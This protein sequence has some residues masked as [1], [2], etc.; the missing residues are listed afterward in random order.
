[1]PHASYTRLEE[2]FRRISALTDA[3]AILQWDLAT[4]MPKGG[5]RGRADQLAVLK[6]LRHS[7]LC[8][9]EVAQLLDA[10]GADVSLDDWQRANLKEMRRAHVLAS[11]VG[12]PE[13]EALSRASSACEA[14]WRDARAESDFSIVRPSLEAL[15]PLVRATAEARAKA[16]GLDPYDAL[17]EEYEPGGRAAEIDP[18]F[19]RLGEALPSLLTAVLERQAEA[20][21]P[22][23][24]RGPFP[25]EAQRRLAV[26]FMERLGFDF[27]H[28]RLD[29][30]LHPF[31]GGTP[32]DVRITTRYDEHD[33]RPALMG[34]LHETGHALYERG[35]PKEW[36][37]LPV[38]DA[39]GMVLHESQ[40]LLIEMQ[41]CRSRAFLAF[42]A[43]LIRATFNG[44]GPAWEAEA[45]YRHYAHVEPGLI[46][47]N[48][49]EVTY[50]AHVI[51][52]YRLEKAL[53]AGTLKVADLPGAW[54]E[55]MRDL[56]GITPP[57]D[58][59]G[60][61][62]DIHWYDGAFGYFPT[63]TL[64]AIAAAQL[65]DA[66]CRA[67]PGLSEG[68]AA[69][70]F[71]P[72]INWLRTHVHSQGSSKSAREILIAATGR[73]LDAEAFVTHLER[74]YLG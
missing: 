22:P 29:V 16:L 42:A 72:L 23:E 61:L 6:A 46:R 60:C 59:S 53:L 12:Q 25:I 36:R 44:S 24:F 65:F 69:G 7:L 17:L 41:V 35:L 63:Y 50:P 51:L 30:S 20:G 38:A 19:A 27:H 74:R 32:D 45:L 70:E 48:A 31:C 52:R 68:I 73:P 4:M 43:P 8:S 3:G 66:A 37:G 10:A 26:Q 56:L 57:D 62:Q 55:G 28:G 15:V 21:P 2:W 11:A 58:R 49:D 39:R 71:A 13:V 40:S 67:E 33:F 34:V 18:I 5:A 9:L 1:M 47:V 14:A 54:A 64:G